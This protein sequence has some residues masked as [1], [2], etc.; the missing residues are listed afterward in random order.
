MLFFTSDTHFA[1]KDTLKSEN[2]PFKTC[3]QFEDF[4]V[5][6]WNKQAKKRDTIYHLGD[7]VSYNQK[8]TKSWKNG[9]AVVKRINAKVILVIGNNEQRL[10]DARFGGSFEDFQKYCINLG[11]ADVKKSEFLVLQG[12]KFYLNHHPINHKQGYVNLFGHTHRATGLW[13]PFGLNVCCDLNHFYLFSE[14][15]IFRL[16]EAKTKW[17]DLDSENRCM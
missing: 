11:F 7:F 16:L 9:L 8:D 5:E 12:K 10:I 1:C 13:K 6:A 2:R 15:E 4:V 17:W 3:K 14:K